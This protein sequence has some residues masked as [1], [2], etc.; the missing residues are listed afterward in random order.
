MAVRYGSLPFDEAIQFFRDKVNVPTDRW[1]DLL[2]DAH[3]RAFMVAGATKTDLLA[4]LRG[5]VDTA[6]SQGKS[7]GAFKRE[8]DS[9]VA[10]HGWEH[11]GPASWRAEVIYNTNMRQSYNAGREAQI[12]RIKQRR[13]YALYRHGDS[14]HPREL[15]LAWN[16]LVLPVDDPWWE[17]HSPSN[18]YGCSCK[19]FLLSEADLKRRGLEVGTAPDNGS[20]EWTDKSTGEV[21]QIPK[22]IDPGFDYRPRS[23]EA[24]TKQLAKQLEAKPPLAERLTPRMVDSAF[25]TAP[26]V[27]A[28]AL[29]QLLE[30]L[31]DA[32]RGA[33]ADY[34]QANPVK[35]LFIKQGEMGK[36]G[37]KLAD[38]VGDYLGVSPVDARYMY[39]SRRA[40]KVNGFTSQ[41]WQ[42]VVVKVKSTDRMAKADMAKVMAGVEDAITAAANNNGPMVKY[43]H[44]TSGEAFAR[45]WSVSSAV[46]KSAGESARRLVTWLHEVGH[47]IHFRA[48]SQKT[49]I[50]EAISLYSASNDL[51]KFAEWFAA[52]SLAPDKVA[53]QWPE[54]ANR[55]EAILKQAT[56]AGGKK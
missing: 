16:N 35:T 11:T 45:H 42:H 23:P 51:E 10:K 50:G 20:Y 31:P 52:W 1:N 5:A 39:Q 38:A 41:A 22:G 44:G 9:I 33:L 8:F 32:S 19:K 47:Q 30:Q 43:P 17:T 14:A 4:D 48:G 36:A 6:I 56:T 46:E 15:H 25:S 27:N 29:S 40:A 34:L 21:H 13:P 3:N 24:L 37:L 49:N 26:G 2:K 54:I 18:G 12:E 7:L 53:G 55:I 28:Q